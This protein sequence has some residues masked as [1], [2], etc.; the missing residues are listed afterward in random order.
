[1]GPVSA[2]SSFSSGV[3]CRALGSFFAGA[4]AVDGLAG[5]YGGNDAVSG[6]GLRKLGLGFEGSS[7]HWTA[8]F[9]RT[10][11]WR[12]WMVLALAL[13]A[14]AAR[15]SRDRFGSCDGGQSEAG[16]GEGG[17]WRAQHGWAETGQTR[18]VVS[19]Q[20]RGGRA[21]EEGRLGQRRMSWS[22]EML[23]GIC[24]PAAQSRAPFT[25]G[26][27]QRKRTPHASATRLGLGP[28]C[29]PRHLPPVCERS[30][31]AFDSATRPNG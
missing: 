7:P 5:G 18:D 29:R 13:A 10:K 20:R 19:A 27:C 11:S 28:S 14:L 24:R 8:A 9:Q 1:M 23:H 26:R 3:D 31:P 25:G 15:G 16:L 17:G 4:M 2:A 6:R 30:F 12:R 22:R 21:S